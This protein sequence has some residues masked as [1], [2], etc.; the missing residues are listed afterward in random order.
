MKKKK[1]NQLLFGEEENEHLIIEKK[2]IN[3]NEDKEPN[4]KSLI[5][6]F[7]SHLKE[8]DKDSFAKNFSIKNKMKKIVDN[9]NILKKKRGRERTKNLGKAVHGKDDFDNLQR[10]IKVHFQKF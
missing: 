2:I 7:V 6:P 4:N 3:I 8:K 9:Q 1:K 10:K 5:P